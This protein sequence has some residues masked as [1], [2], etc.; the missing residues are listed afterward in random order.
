MF[1]PVRL[2]GRCYSL[3]SDACAI[4]RLDGQRCRSPGPRIGG[5]VISAFT[6][7]RRASR[8]PRPALRFPC[9]CRTGLGP[10]HAGEGYRRPCHRPVMMRA[11][12]IYPSHAFIRARTTLKI[13]KPVDA[14]APPR[15]PTTRAKRAQT[16]HAPKLPARRAS[17]RPRHLRRR[18]RLHAPRHRLR[19]RKRKPTR[20]LQARA[21]TE[22]P[23]SPS[24][25]RWKTWPP[26]TV[27][28]SDT[29]KRRA[30][31]AARPV[32]RPPRI[33]ATV[34]R[35]KACAD[36]NKTSMIAGSRLPVR[37]PNQR[38]TPNDRGARTR[39]PRCLRHNARRLRRR[40]RLA[41]RIPTT[42]GYRSG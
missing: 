3:M 36:R 15:A 28:S 9:A 14:S 42:P 16:R 40:A 21:R 19:R 4:F 35:R 33:V 23:R 10:F 11:D 17:W 29:T 8:R 26:A 7:P 1:S 13:T 2:C 20:R 6:P 41:T 31:G 5:G 37:N 12:G 38:T 30:D 39:G 27:A 25:S 34:R 24:A 18:K 32:R 22:A